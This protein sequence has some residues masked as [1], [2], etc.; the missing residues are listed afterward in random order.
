MSKSKEHISMDSD[1]AS[2]LRLLAASEPN[3]N[4]SRTCNNALREY[5]D[6]SKRKIAQLKKKLPKA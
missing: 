6:K 1:V 2:D 5:R 3:G 4:F